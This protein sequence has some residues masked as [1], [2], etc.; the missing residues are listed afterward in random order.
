MRNNEQ[1]T[2]AD[3]RRHLG[4]R[5]AGRGAGCLG[6]SG[7]GKT[8]LLN[9]LSGR[10]KPD[11]GEILLNGEPLTKR[12][13]R[14]VCYVL[15]EDIFFANLTLRQTLTY[16]AQLRLPER[17]SR[18]ERERHVDHIIS[19]LELDQCQHTQIGEYMKGGLS[20][21]EKK[22]ANIGCELLTNP[23]IMLLDEPSTGLDSSATYSLIRNL[24]DYAVKERKTIVLTV[25]Q[26]SSQ[27]FHTFDKLLLLCDGQMAYFG[28]AVD[29]VNHFGSLG[30]F[31]QRHYN[32]ADFAMEQVKPSSPSR[33][34]V[35]SAAAAAAAAETRLLTRPETPYSSTDSL[36]SGGSV[37]SGERPPPDALRSWGPKSSKG[38][39]S[40][41]PDRW[42]TSFWT[43]LKVLTA[44]NV[45]EAR[46]R[47]LSQ[48]NLLLTVVLALLAGLVW[49]RTERSE[50]AIAD[51]QGWIFFSTNYWML[52]SL[53]G[54]LFA[55]PSQQKVVNKE[56]ASGAYR[57]SA[58]YLARLAGELPLLLAPPALYF[59]ISYPML[60]ASSP[61]TFGLLLLLL[62]LNS[63]VAESVGLF[64]GVACMDL[65]VGNTVGAIFTC[66]AQLFS[67]FLS[68]HIPGWLGWMRYL[69]VVFYAYQ[70]MHIVEFGSGAPFS[71]SA[72][73]ALRFC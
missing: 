5:A 62:L 38:W 34:L 16:V 64:V 51:F 7:S 66:G 27:V 61:L 48:L 10:L 26:P 14:S 35:L 73:L 42:P 46:P 47:V 53:F 3:P 24:K 1:S 23:S 72:V 49:L 19:S 15:Q 28:E 54:A 69:S 63:V 20:G 11:S 9:V 32:P 60:G 45:H 6:P 40:S 68:T 56:R 33:Q 21:G 39:R 65:Q 4:P 18:A 71:T 52:F 13:K 36:R 55:L 17:L 59:V 12:L 30:L 8:T 57:L 31:I 29:V 58:F 2:R 22:R 67:G 44:R 25:H 70:N 41:T 37:D 50:H 43:Q